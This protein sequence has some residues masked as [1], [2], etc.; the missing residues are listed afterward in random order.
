MVIDL[1]KG[2][3]FPRV[4]EAV[5]LSSII[6]FTAKMCAIINFIKSHSCIAVMLEA[7]QVKLLILVRPVMT[8][9]TSHVYT[10][11]AL[12]GQSFPLQ[13]LVLEK[14]DEMLE[15][16]RVRNNGLEK[17]KAILMPFVTEIFAKIFIFL[18]VFSSLLRLLLSLCKPIIPG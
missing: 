13:T 10:T 15:T 6:S 1:I 9:W 8:R 4:A 5:T 17:V 16:I 18:H 12:C 14:H 11:K 7:K 3:L 2:S